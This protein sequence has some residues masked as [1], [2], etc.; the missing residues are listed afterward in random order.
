MQPGYFS[1]PFIV[2]VG[3]GDVVHVCPVTVGF[4]HKSA[5]S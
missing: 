5:L 2:Q 4:G 3:A 1:V